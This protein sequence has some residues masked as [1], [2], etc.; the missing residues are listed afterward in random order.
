VT[1]GV[2]LLVPGGA[3]F[4][5]GQTMLGLSLLLAFVAAWFSYATGSAVVYARI[6]CL[7]LDLLVAW[8]SQRQRSPVGQLVVGLLCWPPILAAGWLG[9]G[10]DALA[11]F[12]RVDVCSPV[13]ECWNGCGN[14]D[15]CAEACMEGVPDTDRDAVATFVACSDRRCGNVSEARLAG[16]EEEHCAEELAGCVKLV[17]KKHRPLPRRRFRP[18]QDWP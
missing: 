15:S 4:L 17:P 10:L 16:C 8:R 13:F 5:K 1:L 11:Q 18:R 3:T 9:G 7:V 2:A 14:D 12:D 6:V